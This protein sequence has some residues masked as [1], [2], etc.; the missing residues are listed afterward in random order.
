VFLSGAIA[1]AWGAY[2][3]IA[4]SFVP[5]G[6]TIYYLR[7][8]RQGSYYGSRRA[9]LRK[10]QYWGVGAI[11]MLTIALVLLILQPSPAPSVSVELNVT[12]TLTP[13]RIPT[14]TPAP[15]ETAS[16]SPT[17][18]ATATPPFIPTFTPEVLPPEPAMSPLPSA[19]P[20]RPDARIA[21]MALAVERDEDDRPV[22]PG[23]QFKPG[24]HS[25]YAFF[26]Y[27]EMETGYATTFAW[28]AES[29]EYIDSCLETWVWGVPADRQWGERGAA[30]L[31]CSPRGGWQT[32]LYELRVFVDTQLQSVARFEIAE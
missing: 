7:K 24:L 5:L 32:G 18:R 3:L 20:A 4:L 25:V 17:R 1:I 13:T 31:E 9:A 6:L 21:V 26:E 15:T 30:Y 28:Y 27:G 19:I 8:S 29:G 2:V 12:P 22:D 14:L 10:A 11:S 16:P 23:V